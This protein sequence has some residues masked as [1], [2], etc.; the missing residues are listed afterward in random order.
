MHGSDV[1]ADGF[2]RVLVVAAHLD[3]PEFVHGALIA[4]LVD[5]GSDVR[6]VICTDGSRGGDVPSISDVQLIATRYEEQWRAAMVLGVRDVMFLG[7]REGH[8]APSPELRHAIERELRRVQPDL[9]VTHTP[10]RPPAA[11]AL[12]DPDHLAV[13]EATLAAVVMAAAA[14]SGHRVRE[15]WIPGLEPTDHAIEVTAAAVDRQVQAML[16]HRSQLQARGPHAGDPARWDPD[17]LGV[18]EAA[19]QLLREQG[20]RSDEGYEF[21]ARVRRL[22]PDV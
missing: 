8:L 1:A 11:T 16:C 21:A 10:H 7:L 17:R 20:A 15:V 2:A 5:A 22:R 18:V 4:M 12:P 13:G 3:D 14:P 9:V 6:Y 19:K